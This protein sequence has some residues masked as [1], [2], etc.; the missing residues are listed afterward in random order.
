MEFIQKLTELNVKHQT[1]NV[2]KTSFVQKAWNKGL[3]LHVHGWMCDIETG[4]IKDLT[5]TNEDW[6]HIRDIYNY[7]L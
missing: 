1:L 3:N 5:V 7:K 6:D 2:C 4:L